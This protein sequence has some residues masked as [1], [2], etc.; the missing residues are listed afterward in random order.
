MTLFYHI[1]LSFTGGVNV[2]NS[3]RGL[4]TLPAFEW[5]VM[6]VL[7]DHSS[8]SVFLSFFVKPVPIFV[9][10]CD[11]VFGAVGEGGGQHQKVR[12]AVEGAVTNSLCP[13]AHLYFAFHHLTLLLAARCRTNLLS[14]ATV[15]LYSL[16][17]NLLRCDVV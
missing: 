6:P 1:S 14:Q 11:A 2:W 13:L 17:C 8:P 16:E 5:V 10:C 7:R 4:V 9:P 12:S 3:D 15:K